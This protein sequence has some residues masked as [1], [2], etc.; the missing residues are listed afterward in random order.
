MDCTFFAFANGWCFPVY[1]SIQSYSLKQNGV[2]KAH[3]FRHSDLFRSA[4]FFIFNSQA[5]CYGD[6]KMQ[7]RVE[8]VG[9][10]SIRPPIILKLHN[11]GE[12]P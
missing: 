10:D 11:K 2:A 8:I 12:F 5:N 7:Q 3:P 6:R 1:H 4:S 9:A